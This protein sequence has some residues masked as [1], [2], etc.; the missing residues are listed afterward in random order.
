MKNLNRVLRTTSVLGA[1][2]C[3]VGGSVAAQEAKIASRPLTPQEIKD[4]A[5][6]ADT[7]TSGGL[8][9]VGL[10]QPLYLEAQVPSG[11]VV[12]SVDWSLGVVP[13][14][15]SAVLAASI[16]APTVPIYNPGDREVNIVAGRMTLVPDVVGHYTVNA[17]VNTD[18]D[19]IMLSRQVTGAR[20][21]GVG[22][23]EQVFH[24][25]PQCALCHSDKFATWQGTGHATAMTR[26]IDGI[27][28]GHFAAYCL[29]CHNTGYD[30]APLADNGGFDDIARL[31]NWM[32]PATI[33]AGNWDAMPEDL[34]A[35]SNVQCESCH[36]PGEQHSRSGGNPA[37]ISVST[38]SGDCGQCHDA[39]PYH[40]INQEWNLSR[41]AV[42]TRYPTGERRSS[43]VGC[44]SGI[45][46]IDR[47]DGLAE[48]DRRTDYEAITCAT[49][50][51]PHD[52]T[53]PHQLRKIDV[54]ELMNGEQVTGGGKGRI[55]MNCHIARQDGEVYA[56][57][58]HGRFGPH[59]GP[60]TD[61]LAGK[62]AVEYGRHMPSSAHLTAVADSCATCHMQDVDSGNPAKGFAGG[63]TFKPHWD[64]GTAGDASDDVQLT[65]SCVN[66]HGE[67]GS[68]DFPRK[69]Y[70]GDGTIE[71]VQTEVKGLLHELAMYL[72]P[73]NDPEVSVTASYTSSQL[74]AAYNYKFVEEDKSYGIHNLSYAVN[75][76]KASL[77]DLTGDYSIIGDRDND[78]L[79]DDWELTHFG[80]VTAQDADGDADGDGLRNSLELMVGTN[81]NAA[82]SDNDGF[83][84]LAELHTG[85]NPQ[86]MADTPEVGRSSI[87]NAAEM[88][89]HT[90]MGK[91]YQLQS[92]AE[93]G[94]GSWVN[95]GDP[96]AGDGGMVQQFIS[97]RAADKRFYRVI[98]APQP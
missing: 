36:G 1:L 26:K 4:L 70:D 21:I 12:M 28:V 19:P 87:F 95:E 15:S 50:H 27:G 9:N 8:Y 43:C 58:Y 51:D 66:C 23:G 72:P 48:A 60:Q 63:H 22:T 24:D 89:F 52:A 10:G 35:I 97:T 3:V 5:L 85:T 32:F 41:H 38:S 68:F 39:E 56:T 98:E 78:N 90:E 55:C 73:L 16:L 84:D 74:K 57:E 64:G 88:L 37:F 47:A 80:S 44:H 71:G 54:V 92:V 81:P 13:Q 93:L 76:L 91:S 7:Q 45:G 33:Q 25:P 61:M 42:A 31:Q 75:L 59:H 18:G 49:C 82:D 11:T 86:D 34:K 6:P 29:K 94:A 20:F 67:I 77:A 17:T 83:G 69:D 40:T 62:N 2:V 65:Q 30:T 46:F 79:P 53:N 96:F 14:G